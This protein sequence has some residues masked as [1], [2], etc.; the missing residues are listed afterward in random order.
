[1]YT[2]WRNLKTL[3]GHS[4]PF[5]F[6]IH[7]HPSHPQPKMNDIS[8]CTLVGLLSTKLGRY[9]NINIATN[10]FLIYNFQSDTKNRRH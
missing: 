8:F 1:M 6:A 7:F 10:M 4:D 9:F 2:E 3:H 5:Q